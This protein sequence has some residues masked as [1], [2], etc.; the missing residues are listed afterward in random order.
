[1]KGILLCDTPGR[2][3]DGVVKSTVKRYIPGATPHSQTNVLCGE[4]LV[5]YYQEGQPF[6]YQVYNDPSVVLNCEVGI[7]SPLGEEEFLLLEAI[8]RPADRI[9]AF[10][11][12]LEFG[13]N[14]QEGASVTVTLKGANLSAPPKAR[15]VVHYKGRVGNQTGTL[16][17]VEVLVCMILYTT[18]NLALWGYS[19]IDCIHH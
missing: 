12:K 5:D 11:H 6:N 10:R 17:G 2:K 3:Y 14:L 8:S 13:V 1:M 16:F 4:L 18:L 9:E 7:V 15:A 19:L